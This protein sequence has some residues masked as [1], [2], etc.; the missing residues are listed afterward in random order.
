MQS[1]EELAVCM[2]EMSKPDPEEPWYVPITQN[3]VE[4]GKK[5]L[6]MWCDKM[7]KVPDFPNPSISP[8][9]SMLN[10]DIPE[11]YFAA[12]GATC[13]LGQE[14]TTLT[15]FVTLKNGAFHMLPPY[16]VAANSPEEGLL[17][18]H[19]LIHLQTRKCLR[20]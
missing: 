19:L 2:E 15:L 18:E 7:D 4:R 6:H 14:E 16:R 17:F 5:L 20:D 1:Y 13:R 11:L 10:K 9:T 3:L 8:S 12:P